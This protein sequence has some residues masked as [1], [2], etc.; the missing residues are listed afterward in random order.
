[1]RLFI[2][3]DQNIGVSPERYIKQIGGK[4]QFEARSEH[5]P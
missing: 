1:L 3:E 2:G 4:V 5:A